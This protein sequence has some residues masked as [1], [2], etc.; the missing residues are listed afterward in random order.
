[1]P[2]C[3]AEAIRDPLDL[4]QMQQP[5]PE[6]SCTDERAYQALGTGTVFLFLYH[7]KNKSKPISI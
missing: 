1:M 3:V 6:A 4:E 5:N 2:S 7:C